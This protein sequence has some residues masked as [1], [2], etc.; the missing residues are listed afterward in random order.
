VKFYARSEVW[1]EAV[2][3]YIADDS[4]GIRRPV[5]LTM[6]VGE[7]IRIGET[8][9]SPSWDMTSIDAQNLIDALWEAGLRPHDGSGSGAQV[10]ALKA[11]LS[12]MRAIVFKIDQKWPT[13]ARRS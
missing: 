12:D 13:T 1:T 2:S 9:P 8:M 11:H 3:I 5:T 7:P 6:S 4:D 10:E